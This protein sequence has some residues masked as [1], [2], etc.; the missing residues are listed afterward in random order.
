[1]GHWYCIIIKYSSPVLKLL[2]GKD[3]R[4]KGDFIGAN[5]V[6]KQ[7]K[8]GPTRRRVGMIVEE[9]PARRKF[10]VILFLHFFISIFMQKA[11]RYL[12]NPVKS[13]S[14]NSTFYISGTCGLYFAL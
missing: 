12:G 3:R 2:V 6:Q 11:P 9:A 14:V 4:Q 8:E 1:M 7:L 13:L 10:H 5:V